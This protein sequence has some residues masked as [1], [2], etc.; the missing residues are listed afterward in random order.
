[1][2]GTENTAMGFFSG[3]RL[4]STLNAACVKGKYIPNSRVGA[5]G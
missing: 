1:M 2:I 4:V 3:E 5:S